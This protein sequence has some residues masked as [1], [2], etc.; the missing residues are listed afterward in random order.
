MTQAYTHRFTEVHQLAGTLDP[1]TYNGPTIEYTPYVNL[2]HHQRGVFIVQ[3]GTMGAASTLLCSLVQSTNANG[4]D[5]K[6]IGAVADKLVILQQTEGDGNDTI[7]IEFRT[8]ELDVNAGYCYIA[9]TVHVAG[10]VP[11]SAL[12]L[13][14]GS[15]QLAVPTAMWTQIVD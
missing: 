13:L 3:V 1:A 12:L 14:G 9:G 4:T 5:A 8:D 7:A 11:L 15:N 2:A 6:S 10:D